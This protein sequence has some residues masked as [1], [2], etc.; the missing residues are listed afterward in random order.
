MYL[1]VYFWG[2]GIFVCIMNFRRSISGVRIKMSL[3]CVL[4]LILLYISIIKGNS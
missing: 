3:F 1:V 2:S 4:V